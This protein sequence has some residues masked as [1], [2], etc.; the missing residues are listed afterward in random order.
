[1][2]T[3]SLDFGSLEI[4]EVGVVGP[5]KVKYVLREANGKAAAD[6]RNAI[7][8]SVV[9]GPDGKVS[10]L[11]GM[12]S[13]E[14]IFVA[15]C[16]WDEHGRN[17]YSTVVESWPARVQKELYEK[18]KELSDFGETDP[19]R[20]ALQKALKRS[21]SPI[22]LEVLADWAL[23]LEDKDLKPFVRLFEAVETKNS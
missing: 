9:V 21:D 5:N 1:M 19:I 2:I 4:R 6:H 17:P 11:K 7:L 14:A 15:A 20:D 18:A 23:K 10:S 3:E 22:S 13:I 8:N 16:L 12:A